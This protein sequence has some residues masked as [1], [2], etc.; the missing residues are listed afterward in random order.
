MKIDIKLA[1]ALKT[2]A[3]TVRNSS[4][5]IRETFW[6]EGENLYYTNGNF[7]FRIVLPFEDKQ[8]LKTFSIDDF[9]KAVNVALAVD[10]RAKEVELPPLTD[11]DMDLFDRVKQVHSSAVNAEVFAAKG[12]SLEPT[13]LEICEDVAAACGAANGYGRLPLLFTEL[14]SEGFASGPM[15]FRSEKFDAILMPCKFKYGA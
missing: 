15:V 9:I 11:N 3:G 13:L 8:S 7:M 12:F 6:V 4:S 2:A 10:K 1:K 5:K 14:D